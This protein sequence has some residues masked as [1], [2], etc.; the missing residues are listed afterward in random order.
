[1]FVVD[2]SGSIQ[3]NNPAN[4]SWD[5]WQLM[6][7][8]MIAIVRQSNV[9]FDGTHVG[10]VTFGNVGTRRFRLDKHR[11][12]E[13]VVRAIEN[14]RSGNGETNMY[15]GLVQMRDVFT[16]KRGGRPWV[17]KL[18]IMLTD[19]K[20]N[21]QVGRAIPEA[22]AAYLQDGITIL[23]IGITDKIDV[24]QIK[25][26]SSPPQKFEETYWTSTD[27][28]SLS[29]VIDSVQTETCDQDKVV[30]DGKLCG[31]NVSRE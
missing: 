25:K 31:L 13:S 29:S 16:E 14:L 7:D 21:V 19:G 3:D 1:M 30:Y 17:K 11:D 27:F 18:A 24:E 26:I 10:L 4:R 6:K 28:Q 9:S 12:T 8:F 5:N 15:A 23:V 2:H 22:E 20:A